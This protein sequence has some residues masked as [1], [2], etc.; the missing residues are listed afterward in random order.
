MSSWLDQ[1]C[2]PVGADLQTLMWA[3]LEF[4][5]SI[6]TTLESSQPDAVKQMLAQA[7]AFKIGEDG[8]VRNIRTNGVNWEPTPAV[9]ITRN[10]VHLHVCHLS[11]AACGEV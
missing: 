5:S 1:C 10:F 3:R 9:S 8:K 7:P 2:R 6:V 11:A 4:I